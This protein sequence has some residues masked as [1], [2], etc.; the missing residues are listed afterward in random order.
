MTGKKNSQASAIE[1]IKKCNLIFDQET[2]KAVIGG[3]AEGFI[4]RKREKP[5]L[6]EFRQLVEDGNVAEFDFLS[7]PHDK[8]VGNFIPFVFRKVLHCDNMMESDDGLSHISINM[9]EKVLVPKAFFDETKLNF[10]TVPSNDQLSLG[11]AELLKRMA[12][13]CRI[14]KDGHILLH[15]SDNGSVAVSRALNK[16]KLV[17]TSPDCASILISHKDEVVALKEQGSELCIVVPSL[18]YGAGHNKDMT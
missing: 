4:R 5:V 11:R 6:P 2:P 3:N 15:C 9:T 8:G 16:A 12:F 18:P 14:S 1:C 10:T 13:D 17:I 7:S